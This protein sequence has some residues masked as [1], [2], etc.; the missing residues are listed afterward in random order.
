MR[1]FKNISRHVTG[2]CSSSIERRCLAQTSLQLSRSMGTESRIVSCDLQDIKIPDLTFSQMCWS[3]LDQYK[4][5]VALVDAVSG[6]SFTFSEARSLARSFG[7]GLLRLGGQPG[8]VVAIVLP[9][10]PE[11]PVVFMGASEA[12]FVLTTLNP[13]Y[14][15]GEIRGQLV[16]SEAKYVVTIPQL[17]A[18]VKESTAG[19]DIEIIAPGNQNDSSCISLESLL[20]DQLGLT[21]SSQ[22]NLTDIAVMPYSSGTTGVPK[23][24][25]LTHR[26][27]V[28]NMAQL[29]HPEMEFMAPEE[30]TVCVLPIFHIFAMN[31]TMSNMLFNGGKMVTVPMF[32]PNMFLKTLLDHR[33]TFLHLA[34]PLVGFLATHPAVTPEHLA[35]VQTIF[36]GAAPAGQALI[37][38][39]HKRAP[40]VRFREGFG[41]TEMAPAITFSRGHI[42]SSGSTGQL[43]PNMKMKTL[44]LTTGEEM[45]AGETGELCF[46]GPNVM[47]GYFKNAEATAETLFD[48]WLHTG[49]IGYYDQ[50]GH[51]FLVDRKKE[52]I[53][54]KG[55]Q[56]AP[57]ELENLI[58]SLED[59]QDVAVIGVPDERSGEV[60]RAY[61]VKKNEKLVEK[62][63]EDFVAAAL[64]KHKHLAGGVQF[65][66]EI[67][68]S[69][70]GKILRKDLKA[71][72]MN[73]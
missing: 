44:D 26:N 43:L 38:M 22:P 29:A 62:D 70:A 46:Q 47:P 56:V 55:L 13:A 59:V 67:P 25:M 36:V 11:Y 64:S 51:V 54:V 50:D 17:L 71:S 24:V 72:Y 27:L 66:K 4:D 73:Q 41:M 37:N 8:D 61:V 32:E 60:P 53:K 3:R 23:G 5:N 35:S 1:G 57:A 6:R 20:S 7:S 18:K 2:I 52:L 30:V 68:K 45:K 63:V 40:N 9:N 34:P 14:T 49:D 31:V 65:V 16:N 58:R 19:T 39:F 42:S 28:A 69:A 12:G 48:G 21:P 15:A 10:L 33:P